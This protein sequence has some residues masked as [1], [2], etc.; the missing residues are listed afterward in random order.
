MKV[1]DYGERA[2]LLEVEPERVSDYVETLA[3]LDTPEIV[4][5]VP[6]AQTVLVEV[7]SASDLG[8]VRFRLEDLQPEPAG[9]QTNEE[10]EIDITYDGPDLE[11]IA[12]QARLSVDEVVAAHSGSVFRVQFCG[13]S[14]GFGYLSGLDPRL[15]LPRRQSPRTSVPAGS[16]SIANAY[17]AVYTATTPGG[18]H[19]IGRT[20]TV[21]FDAARFD[22]G[23]SPALFRPGVI[24]RF[25]PK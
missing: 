11:W 20:D 3:R 7:R 13:F 25:R 10:V 15:H 6:A 21:L 16:V 9:P 18:W 5:I 22:H 14:P 19:L 17:S 24:V 4:S 2:L 12:E 23:E 1:L 8:P